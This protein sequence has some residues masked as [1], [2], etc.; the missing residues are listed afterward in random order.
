MSSSWSKAILKK[1]LSLLFFVGSLGFSVFSYAGGFSAE[2]IDPY[3]DR[4][5]GGANIDSNGMGAM[6]EDKDGVL[7]IGTQ[8]GL[9]RYDGYRFRRFVPVSGD[10]NSLAGAY[11]RNLWLAP[12]GKIWIG[13]LADGLSILDPRTERFENQRNDPMQSGSIGSGTINAISIDQ[14]TAAWVATEHALNY[15]APGSLMWKQY[16]HNAADQHSLASDEVD[17]L[18]HDRHGNLWIGTASGLQKLR[19]DGHGFDSVASDPYDKQSLAGKSVGAIFEAADGK[20]WIA[21]D[22]GGVAWLD[23]QTLKLHW[24][25]NFKGINFLGAR[26]VFSIAQ[27]QN[28]QIWMATESGI[29]ILSANDGRVLKSIHRDLARPG[30]LLAEEVVSL[31]VDHIGHVWVGTGIG[32]GLQRY[33]PQNKAISLIQHSD[34]KPE[35]LSAGY[36]QSILELSNGDIL[37]AV[38]GKGVDIFNREKGRIGNYH[39]S[40]FS[41]QP[42]QQDWVL[43]MAQMPD[44]SLWVDDAGGVGLQRLKPGSKNW[45]TYGP[46]QGLPSGVVNVMHV[47]RDGTLWLG[48]ESGIARWRDKED[49]FEVIPVPEQL[50]TSIS[51]LSEDNNRHL[52]VGSSAGLWSFLLDKSV[53]QAYTH[54]A[55]RPESLISDDVSSVLV[56]HRGRVWVSTKS[57][58]DLLRTD[59][60]KLPYFEHISIEVGDAGEYFGSGLFE[61]KHGR[62]WSA[63]KLFDPHKKRIYKLSRADG[64]DVGEPLRGA[65]THTRDG[66]LLY[67]GTAGVAVINPE[68]FFPSSYQ[69][70]VILTQVKIDDQNKPLGL[71]LDGLTIASN[72]RRFSIEFAALDYSAPEKIQYRYRLQAHDKFWVEADAEHRVASYGNLWPGDYTLLIRGTNR[73]GD[74][75]PHELRI[76]IHVLPAYWQTKWF[77]ILLILLAI[78]VVYFIVHKRTQILRNQKRILETIVSQRTAELMVANK[79]AEEDKRRA[80]DAT[81]AKSA[82][83]ANMSHEIRTPMNAIIGMNH[84]VLKTSLDTKQRDYLLKVQQSSQ[85]LLRIIDDILDLSKVEAGKLEL[86]IH[87]FDLEQVLIKVANLVDEKAS[88]KGLELLFDIS[89]DVPLRLLGDALR[90]SQMLINY[91]NNAIKFTSAGEI[92]LIVRVKERDEQS[93]LL[94][95][96][97]RDT[98]IGLSEEQINRLFKEFQ[99]ADTATSRQYGGTGLGLAITKILATQMSGDVGVDSRLGEGSCFWFTARLGLTDEVGRELRLQVDLRGK[100]VLVVD[101]AESTREVMEEMLGSMS[102]IVAVADSGEA[103]IKEIARADAAG[104]PYEIVLLDWKMPGLNGLETAHQIYQM[105]LLHIPEL[106]ILTAFG[107]EDV[108]DEARLIGI[109]TVLSKPIG[110]SML[111]DSMMGLLEGT[112]GTEAQHHQNFSEAD[113]QSIAGARILLAEDNELNQQVVIDLLGDAGLKVQIADNGKVACAMAETGKYDLILMDMQMPVMDGIEAARTIKSFPSCANTPI[114]AM[115][116][117]VMQGVRELCIGAGMIDHVAK[118]IEPDQLFQVLLRLIR[119]RTLVPNNARGAGESVLTP[120]LNAIG[121]LQ[122]ELMSP[123]EVIPAQIEGLDIESGMR[124]VLGR[125]P[126]YWRMLKG[127][128]YTQADA[129]KKMR[130]ALS[131]NDF[132]ETLRIAHTLRGLAGNIGSSSLVA[133]TDLFEHSINAKNNS[134]E[135]ERHLHQLEQVLLT[136][137]SAIT[138]ALPLQENTI[139]QVPV[140]GDVVMRLCAQLRELLLND[141]GD[142]ERLIH[143][144]AALLK[145][146]FPV[147]YAVMATAASRFDF[148]RTLQILDEALQVRII[149]KDNF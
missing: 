69:P 80:E 61:D 128:A 143:E 129:V 86:D 64:M 74:W 140:D 137:I 117:D 17:S 25:E 2:L 20:L 66:L 50:N 49:L 18:L 126:R 78:L 43:A 134:D 102:F 65:N 91:T 95:F 14:N 127:F 138:I 125:V 116:A 148:E 87:P 57:G 149:K 39:P 84:L 144:N 15:R 114:V 68:L 60:G 75:S 6:I 99:Q 130:E 71:L 32:G 89:S 105:D 98:G 35:S 34:S 109:R 133:A 115:T 145:T 81:A 142:A 94:Y 107:R 118:P 96:A 52:W 67:G 63:E 10:P 31:L 113:L 29:R 92:N 36:V 147:Q 4:V 132:D 37:V 104:K 72:Q 100:R 108:A 59:E 131:R 51:S 41:L 54:D 45:K 120:P 27:P 3:F 77:L 13:T 56:D 119:P 16:R 47:M 44:G 46:D 5:Y 111:F 135:L 103:A 70:K 26:N 24:P 62:I 55:K 88:S 123:D 48:T 106:A 58:L 141:D 90:L 136:Q 53:W 146:V 1:F 28:D 11:V 19:A 79:H 33:N 73:V 38:A 21:V 9:L 101:D 76:P 23:A 22:G 82:F 124:R 110:P 8:F 40:S 42:M 30:T 85:H 97:V 112:A 121:G 83:L 93:V 7:W 139:M 12:D 122:K